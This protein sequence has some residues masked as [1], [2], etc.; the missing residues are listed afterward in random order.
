MGCRLKTV[1]KKEKEQTKMKNKKKTLILALVIA[2]VT[3]FVV[4]QFYAAY[5]LPKMDEESMVLSKDM[6]SSGKPSD[7]LAD[8][9][10]CKDGV[11]PLVG[12]KEKC[13]VLSAK[14]TPILFAGECSVKM[15][16]VHG[17]EACGYFETGQQD[18][19]NQKGVKGNVRKSGEWNQGRN[20]C[21]PEDYGDCIISEIL[22][23]NS[24][25]YYTFPIENLDS[26]DSGHYYV[27]FWDKNN[28]RNAS[29]DFILE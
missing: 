19:S 17:P 10:S 28:I 29:M 16:Y 14:A 12:K 24:S 1:I 7:V 25:G 22:E 23:K 21:T 18:S 26:L 3:V 6:D 5:A 4:F 2:A 15:Y 11:L 9:Q 8:Y 27:A 20:Q 13:I